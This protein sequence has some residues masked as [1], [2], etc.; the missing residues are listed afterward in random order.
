MVEIQDIT[1]KVINFFKPEIVCLVEKWLKGG[2][3]MVFDDYE[4]LSH[5]RSRRVGRQ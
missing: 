3:G 2:E 4:C 1:A 5:N